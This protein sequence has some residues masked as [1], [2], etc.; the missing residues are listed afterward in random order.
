MVDQVKVDTAGE[1]A[2]ASFK[3]NTELN[4]WYDF[5]IGKGGNI[6]ALASNST[7]PTT[8]RICWSASPNRHR[9]CTPPSMYHFLLVGNP[10][11]YNL[12]YWDLFTVKE[13]PNAPEYDGHKP[14]DID[15]LVS[16]AKDKFW[17]KVVHPEDCEI[18]TI[19]SI[20]NYPLGSI[21]SG[22][23]DELKKIIYGGKQS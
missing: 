23:T 2:E 5:G 22:M 18:G 8:C 14:K 21:T 15:R 4:Q 16:M 9:I 13:L 12:K 11:H 17:V 6:I 20:G 3:V 19:S 7:A 1:E 10:Y